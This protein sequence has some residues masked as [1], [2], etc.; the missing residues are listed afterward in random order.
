MTRHDSY[1]CALDLLAFEESG[2]TMKKDK[3]WNDMVAVAYQKLK[4]DKALRDDLK[5][6]ILIILIFCK[7]S[8]LSP[9]RTY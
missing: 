1:N 8:Y 6:L 5:K 7:F 3:N 2:M 4:E 9:V